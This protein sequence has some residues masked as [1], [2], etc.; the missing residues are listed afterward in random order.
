[1]T[2]KRRD[3][4]DQ[5]ILGHKDFKERY[6]DQENE[7]YRQE[8]AK[9]QKPKV[10]I[11]SC[12]DSRVNPMIV[13]H[14]NLG[15]VFSIQNVAN[16]VPPY[17]PDAAYHGTSSAIEYA[18]LGLKVEHIIVFGHSGCGGV[19][20]LVEGKLPFEP[21]FVHQWVSILADAKQSVQ[22]DFPNATIDEQCHHCER[23]GV[24]VSLK[25]LLTFPWIKEGVQSQALQLHGWHFDIPTGDITRFDEQ[26]NHFV[27]LG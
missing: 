7:A 23:E 17:Q 11:V 6:L 4:I 22:Q 16:T 2:N 14:I 3:P 13:N 25:N 26:E 27:K 15:Q 20:S 1:M 9:G 21:T 5:L 19:R 12:S 18:V 8:A 10:L 24:K